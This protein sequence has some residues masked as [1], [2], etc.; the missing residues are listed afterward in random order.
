MKV[1]EI[2]GYI[3]GGALWLGLVVTWP[4]WG[5]DLIHLLA[6]VVFTLP[7]PL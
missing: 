6:R 5:I 7:M 4:D 2:S 1:A 3:L